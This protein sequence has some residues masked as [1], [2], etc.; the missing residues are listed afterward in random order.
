M[1]T[2]GAGV[3]AAVGSG[4]ARGVGSGVGLGVGAD[5]RAGPG[6]DGVPAPGRATAVVVGR[7]WTLADGAAPLPPATTAGDDRPAGPLGL[8]VT[9][10]GVPTML[11]TPPVG[12]SGPTK[13]N[14]TTARARI[15]TPAAMTA[16]P[17][18]RGDVEL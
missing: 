15:V 17:L 2:H 1:V 4:V 12:R 18:A 6:V 8:D 9:G 16:D 3:G 5:V 10:P 13:A 14:A 7:C 11:S